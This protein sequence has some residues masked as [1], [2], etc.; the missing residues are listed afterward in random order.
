MSWRD[1]LDIDVVTEQSCTP[2]LL[3][4]ECCQHSCVAPDITS[5]R[6]DSIKPHNPG[7][8]VAEVST[9]RL[10]CASRIRIL[11]NQRHN[12]PHQPDLQSRRISTAHEGTLSGHSLPALRQDPFLPERRCSEPYA[13]VCKAPLCHVSTSMLRQCC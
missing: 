10:P 2:F 11:S 1:Y 6:T 4:S 3:G 9:R 13:I 7:Q 12:R 5:H 8:H